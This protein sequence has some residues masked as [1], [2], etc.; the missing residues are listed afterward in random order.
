[1]AVVGACWPAPVECGVA[2]PVPVVGP[3]PA[4]L[5]ARVHIKEFTYGEDEHR[6]K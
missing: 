1:M 5:D 6:K 4:S 3:E 2:V